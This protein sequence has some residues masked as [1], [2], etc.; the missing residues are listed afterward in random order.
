MLTENL[1]TV[2]SILQRLLRFNME[3]LR[4]TVPALNISAV[5]PESVSGMNTV[6]LFL[7]HAVEDAQTRNRTVGE[8]GRE[9]AS[10]PLV[11]NL[12]FIL[13][14]HHTMEDSL[15]IDPAEQQFLLGLAMKT[16]HDYPL[17]T[18]ATA[19]DRGGP[20]PESVVP[21]DHLGRGTRLDLAMRPV[22][23]ED[24]INFW[25]AESTA[26]VRL[27]GYYEV[28][29]AFLEPE[30]VRRLS[31]PVIDL[32]LYVDPITPIAITAASGLLRF[33]PPPATGLGPQALTTRPARPL[34]TADPAPSD[35]DITLSGTGFGT[36]T[37]A[38]IVLRH[39]DWLRRNP[40]LGEVEIDPALNAPW[41]VSIASDSASLRF[42]GS[43]EHDP[44][45]GTETLDILPG[46]YLVSVRR[47]VRRS[48]PGGTFRSSTM[49]SNL[50]DVPLGAR[51]GGHSGVAGDGTMRLSIEA[52]FDIQSDEV[53]L[54]F[55]VDGRAYSE[56]AA[57]TGVPT[58]DAGTFERTATG[59]LFHPAFDTATPGLHAVRLV[60]NGVESQPFWIT[61]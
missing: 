19:F 59:L 61:L 35:S 49:E 22:T 1:F 10:A 25:S 43:L 48:G 12:F 7:Y 52:L 34:L 5:P 8:V 51:I 46:H 58:D 23:P 13:T 31:A 30:E 40:P 44:G 37:D 14:A 6:N 29:S 18:D 33:D 32:G 24:A 17:I 41:A 27:A 9:I 28:R 36:G 47:S 15:E 55:A 2:T 3:H 50:V 21:A 42:R 45:G 60:A 20:L 39:A 54:A 16:L 38:R 53:G 26:T 4:G 56:V 57:L 11:L